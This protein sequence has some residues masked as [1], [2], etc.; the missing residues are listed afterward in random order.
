MNNK[1]YILCGIPFSG[2]TTLAKRM[3][4]K[5]GFARIDL[6]EVKF[7]LFGTSITDGEI[8]QLGWDKVYQRMYKRIEDLLKTGK[9]VI[10]DTGNFT[11][12][13]RNIVKKIA[14]DLGVESITI[15]VDI[16][17]KEARNRLLENRH[18]KVRFDVSDGDFNS[19]V[20]EMEKPEVG[21][22]HVVCKWRDD[23]DS[24]ADTN[25]K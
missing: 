6:D 18:S 9:T 22:R 3:V 8:D 19:T 2:K 21:E 11:R 12:N 16:P 4:E 5:F 15:Y 13:E 1:L 20:S 10:N 23:F 7:E 17:T 24:W 14:D 25:I